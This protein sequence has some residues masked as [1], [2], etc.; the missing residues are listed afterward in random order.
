MHAT[1][2]PCS[3]SVL[4]GCLKVLL[5]ALLVFYVCL[6][7]FSGA[8]AKGVLAA[9]AR[10]I[11]GVRS[12]FNPVLLVLL[13]LA[14]VGALLLV[15]LPRLRALLPRWRVFGGTALVLAPVALWLGWD[16]SPTARP[17]LPA[18]T[19]DAAS[20]AA[21]RV[22]LAYSSIDG[23]A[24]QRK[25]SRL[26]GRSMM[27]YLKADDAERASAVR[28]ARDDI[29]G[30]WAMLEH[31]ERE[32]IAELN[33]FARIG[34]T[35]V[36]DPAAPIMRFQPIRTV[37]TTAS[38]HAAVLAIEGRGDEAIAALLPILEVASK[39][40]AGSSSLVRIMIARVT[41]RCVLDGIR[42]VLAQT[43]V[44]PGCRERL[45]QVLR[46]TT[47]AQQLAR[48][49]VLVEYAVTGDVLQLWQNGGPSEA[50]PWAAAAR[51]VTFPVLNRTQ[52]MNRWS[53]HWAMMA[54]LATRRDLEGL[55]QAEADFQA[56][57]NRLHLKNALGW[58]LMHMLTVSLSKLLTTHWATEDQRRALMA[59]L[60]T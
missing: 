41:T 4:A 54:E 26:A 5:L 24:P 15:T 48:R 44:S 36:Y 30:T 19:A 51:I 40:E 6:T 11:S 31:S 47:D 55:K 46:H 12:G 20:T 59:Q 38:A 32:W 28:A 3:D 37:S 50:S 57:A 7:L 18:V 23:A 14:C 33:T 60:T 10:G 17:V 35:P 42:F 22:S 21:W 13:A 16:E 49:I 8:L 25:E 2:S 52:T 27:S 1:N 29:E 56:E 58:R 45:L 39:L 9:I 53:D 43:S 34:D